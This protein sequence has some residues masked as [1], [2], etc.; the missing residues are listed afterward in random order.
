MDDRMNQEA[1]HFI[2]WLMTPA[3]RAAAAAEPVCV[4][5]EALMQQQGC[6]YVGQEWQQE[7]FCNRPSLCN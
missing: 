7:G 1:L 2:Y 3:A 4:V 6:D 5:C